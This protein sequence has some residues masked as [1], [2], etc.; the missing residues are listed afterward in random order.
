MKRVVVAMLVLLV[1]TGALPVFAG[2]PDR[3]DQLGVKVQTLIDMQTKITEEMGVLRDKMSALVQQNTDTLSKVTATVDKLD[4]SMQAQQSAN[5]S[6]VDQLTGQAQPL[7]DELT[8]LRANV[9][10]LRR[11]LND[12]NGFRQNAPAAPAQNPGTANPGAK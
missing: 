9:E 11:Q 7:H 1:L 10:A 3:I 2:G 5:D 12:M 6:C 4:K 8:Q